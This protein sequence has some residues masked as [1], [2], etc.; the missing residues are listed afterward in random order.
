MFAF[1]MP[2]MHHQ[3]VSDLALVPRPKVVL[4]FLIAC[5]TLLLFRNWPIPALSLIPPIRLALYIPHNPFTMILQSCPAPV[6][7]LILQ[8]DKQPWS[9]H[10]PP[11]HHT[12]YTRLAL[13]I[14]P[15][16]H[17]LSWSSSK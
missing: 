5:V 6:I 13:S 11:L 17:L 7:F 10:H 3:P 1:V 8:T 2:R 14:L 15:C 4:P 12:Q 9:F 16:I